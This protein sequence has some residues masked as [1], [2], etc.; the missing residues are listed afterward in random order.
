MNFFKQKPQCHRCKRR[1]R[2]DMLEFGWCMDCRHEVYHEILAIIG[3][4][5]GTRLADDPHVL[6]IVWHEGADRCYELIRSYP[7]VKTANTA[8]RALWL[9]TNPEFVTKLQTLTSGH[10]LPFRYE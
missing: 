5:V 6:P 9:V 3:Y 1:Y 8:Y 2:A 4:L 7:D 10:S